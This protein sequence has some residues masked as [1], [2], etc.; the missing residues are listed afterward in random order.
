MNVLILLAS[1]R[2]NIG[3]H[4]TYARRLARGLLERGNA[5][6]LLVS[7][8]ERPSPAEAEARVDLV[9]APSL[10]QIGS[11]SFL[12]TLG[13]LAARLIP[14]HDVVNLHLPGWGAAWSAAWSRV[15]RTPVVLTYHRDVRGLK[16]WFNATVGLGM[17]LGSRAAGLL[18]DRIVYHTEDVARN[19]PY[20]Q[21]FGEKTETIPPPVDVADVGEGAVAAF[22]KMHS[23]D[24][25]GP[26]IGVVAQLAAGDGVDALLG[27]LP[28]VMDEYP[29]ARVLF[30]GDLTGAKGREV[31]A[32]DLP[33]L[34]HR[35]EDRWTSL[36]TL[37]PVQM[38]ALYPNLDAIVVPAVGSTGSF[39]LAQ[40]EAMLCGT[41]SIASDLPG[42][43]EPVRQTG[44]GEVVPVGDSAALA[45]AVIRVVSNR[46]QYVRPREEIEKRWS[47]E[48]T[49]AEYEALFE[50]LVEARTQRRGRS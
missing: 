32:R 2:P 9:V 15:A 19:S 41:P 49:A 6:T 30:A 8:Q 23:L 33:S 50:R 17:R 21:A 46:P 11:F 12:P 48:R 45:Q 39:C 40:A 18:A 36:G 5:V 3:G 4:G 38:A 29:E 44:M 24:E 43:R 42:M 10:V 22:R 34:F 28:R 14:D 13:L 47:T 20:L 27:A 25:G 37:R 35:Y 26:V 31:W 7:G 1:Y 16:G